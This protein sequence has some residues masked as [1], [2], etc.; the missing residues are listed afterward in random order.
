M[1]K[2]AVWRTLFERL[3]P[4]WSRYANSS[5]LSG[6]RLLDL[7]ARHVPSLSEINRFL[8]PRTGFR[9]VP[10]SGYL[11]APDFF[12]HL[13][14]REFPTVPRLRSAEQLDY[15]PEPDLFH[16][17]CGHVPMHA[18]PSFANALVRIGDCASRHPDKLDEIARF[19]WFTVEFGLMRE[20]GELKAYGSGLLSSA[21]E[22]E[23]AMTC[24]AVERRPFDLDEVLSQSFEIDR[25]QNRVYIVESFEHLYGLAGRLE[26]RL[27]GRK[28]A[29]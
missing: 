1:S 11:A 19:F 14:R 13:R 15:L 3:Q 7:R 27:S 22:L 16:D 24:D 18:N 20:G 23:H 6:L 29:A 21:A 12:A 17:V 10:V 25:L 4:L 5:Y 2:S 26:W 9:A 28:L 8:A